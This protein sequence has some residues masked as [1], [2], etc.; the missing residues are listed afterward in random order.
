MPG[1][2]L[3]ILVTRCNRQ[4]KGIIYQMVPC[5]VGGEDRG[6]MLQGPYGEERQPPAPPR[7]MM[8]C[9]IPGNPPAGKNQLPKGNERRPT[10]CPGWDQ[11]RCHTAGLSPCPGQRGKLQARGLAT[12]RQPHCLGKALHCFF[13]HFLTHYFFHFLKQREEGSPEVGLI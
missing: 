6:R 3:D 11:P 4:K 10:V 8:C 13:R 7:R 12:Y 1:C 5:R 9:S 2:S